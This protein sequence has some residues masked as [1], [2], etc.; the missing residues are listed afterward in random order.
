MAHVLFFPSAAFAALRT[1]FSACSAAFLL[2]ELRFQLAPSTSFISGLGSTSIGAL[3]CP[4]SFFS[5]CCKAGL[6]RSASPQCWPA[7]Q[8][9]AVQFKSG[10]LL[11]F[12]FHCQQLHAQAVV[13]AIHVHL[14]LA[15][16]NLRAAIACTLRVRF[17]CLANLRAAVA[18]CS[19]VFF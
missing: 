8:A 17:C 13:A 4:T 7:C 15:W 14:P 1:A 3:P 2:Y 12:C 19:T 9:A 16:A 11:F 18:C 10:S 5:S 6:I